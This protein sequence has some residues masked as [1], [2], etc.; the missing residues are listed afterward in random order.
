MTNAFKGLSSVQKFNQMIPQEFSSVYSEAN[1]LPQANSTDNIKFLAEIGK[2]LLGAVHPTKV[3]TSIASGAMRQLRASRCAFSVKLDEGGLILRAFEQDGTGCEASFSKLEFQKWL[4]FLPTQV[5]FISSGRKLFINKT[6]RREFISPIRIDNKVCGAIV[7]GYDFDNCTFSDLE[8]QTTL[9][10][11]AQMAALSLSLAAHFTR[12]MSNSIKAAR[13][14][15]RKFTENVLDALPISLYVIDKDFKIVIWNQHRELGNQGEA[16]DCVLGKNV[17]E[18]L[19]NKPTKTL[20]KEFERVFRTGKLERVEHQTTDENG[21]TKYWIISKVPMLNSAGICTHVIT[22]GEDVTARVDAIHAAS[23]AEKL[24][25]VGRLAAGVVHEINNPIAT[26]S[27]CAE[28]LETRVAE[29]AY[30]S[31]AD[32]DDLREYLGL[33]RDESFRCKSITNGLLDFSR[34]RNGSRFPTVVSELVESSVLLL[35]HQKRSYGVEFEVEIEDSLPLIH[36]DVGQI[37]QAIIALSTN[38][39]DAMPSGGTV[40]FRAYSENRQV[41]IE[42][43]DTGTGIEP[44]DLSKIFEPFFTTKDFGRGTGLGLAVTYGIV[45]DHN[46]KLSV[47]SK[48][49]EGSTFLMYLPIETE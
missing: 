2:S 9:E 3:A 47:R 43:S 23:R 49:G 17:L 27:A 10:A 36:A 28:A 19:S 30:D 35:K 8:I 7:L 11:L 20:R 31:S 44:K 25:A 26:I 32:I 6:E 1:L 14:E 41:V 34:C 12:K 39:I 45:T 4:G 37:Q 13:E 5:G 29:G 48:L 21:V 33:I 16:R 15:H 18:V 40:T 22:I 24:A 42:I 46:G 38:A